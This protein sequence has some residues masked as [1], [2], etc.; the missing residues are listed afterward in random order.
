LCSLDAGERLSSVESVHQFCVH[1]GLSQSTHTQLCTMIGWL[2][3]SR[4]IKHNFVQGTHAEELGVQTAYTTHP[5]CVCHMKYYYN[6][7]KVQYA[8]SNI[9]QRVFFLY[10]AYFQVFL[11]SKPQNCGTFPRLGMLSYTAKPSLVDSK[12]F[13]APGC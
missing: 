2:Y 4:G 9:F 11:N 8:N 6:K 3:E 7:C 13:F 5:K 10:K 1:T 12:P